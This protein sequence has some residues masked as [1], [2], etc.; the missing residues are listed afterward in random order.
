MVMALTA[1][2]FKQDIDLLI[3]GLQLAAQ[4]PGHFSSFWPADGISA[5]PMRSVLAWRSAAASA[6]WPVAMTRDVS[7]AC[8]V[9]ACRSAGSASIVKTAAFVSGANPR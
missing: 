4:R 2:P 7:P 9:R 1:A 8:T 6:A 5:K 3:E